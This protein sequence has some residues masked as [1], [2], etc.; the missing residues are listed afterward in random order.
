MLI[1]MIIG[2]LDS[3]IDNQPAISICILSHLYVLSHLCLTS[4]VSY[5][6]Y[7]YIIRTLSL[8]S[9]Y[10]YPLHIMPGGYYQHLLLRLIPPTYTHSTINS[11]LYIHII[12][13]TISP[14]TPSTHSPWNNHWWLHWGQCTL[15]GCCCTY[16]DL[17][18]CNWQMQH[19]NCCLRCS[20]RK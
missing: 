6:I 11:Y 12:T 10:S 1:R 16:L 7:F 4:F 3:R 8:S 20:S 2:G 17:Q 18:C 13:F 14:R 5:L 19:M 9:I 15:P